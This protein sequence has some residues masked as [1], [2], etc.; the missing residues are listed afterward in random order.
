M[1]LLCT[2]ASK[3]SGACLKGCAPLHAFAAIQH[4]G[5]SPE[6]AFMQGGGQILGKL[7]GD[8]GGKGG[9]KSCQ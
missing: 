6:M 2:Y 4:P 8:K 9:G 7:T 3:T 5:A 1:A